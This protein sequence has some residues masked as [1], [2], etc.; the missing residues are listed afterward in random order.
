MLLILGGG[1]AAFLLLAVL[2]IVIVLV[3]DGDSRIAVSPPA[4]APDTQRQPPPEPA[5]RQPPADPA[6]RQPP[7]QPEPRPA[8]RESAQ[9]QRFTQE[10][11]QRWGVSADGCQ[12]LLRAGKPILQAADYDDAIAVLAA[13]F[14]RNQDQ[15]RQKV[16]SIV[17]QRGQEAAQRIVQAIQAMER[18]C[19]DVR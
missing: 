3:S 4:P 18:D 10:C 1:L 2:V 12:C 14:A 15:I 16:Q 19:K 9:E 6:P 8:A 13:I 11:T 7:G 17:A 5:P